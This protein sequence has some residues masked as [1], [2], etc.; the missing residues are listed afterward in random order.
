MRSQP[1]SSAAQTAASAAAGLVGQ[2]TSYKKQ[3][4][5]PGK[6][7]KAFEKKLPDEGREEGRRPGD[8]AAV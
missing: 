1:S 2:A 3:V 6:A 8:G 5:K 4:R 7:L